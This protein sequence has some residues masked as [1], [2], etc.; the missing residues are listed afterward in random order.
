MT[1][2]TNEEIVKASLFLRKQEDDKIKE[3]SYREGLKHGKDIGQKN[4]FP[5][6]ESLAII[7]AVIGLLCFLGITLFGAIKY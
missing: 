3:D 2:P 6:T 5:K 4:K 7:C 1:R